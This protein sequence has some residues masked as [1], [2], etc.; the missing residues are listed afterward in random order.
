MYKPSKTT[1]TLEEQ[2]IFIKR[3]MKIFF[4]KFG[5]YPTVSLAKNKKENSDN[6]NLLSLNQL[7]E[8]FNM[9]LPKLYGKNVS[10][11]SKTRIRE[12][13]ELRHIFCYIAKCMHFKMVTIG[14]FLGKRDHSTV[15][16][17]I[18]TFENLHATDPIFREKYER[19]KKHIKET[20]ESSIMESVDQAWD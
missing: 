9:F 13:T 10:L 20:Y 4:T 8:C 16:H 1:Q 14:E 18:R 11:V 2:K 19:V 5:Y 3:F 6:V 17:S 7:S 15:I 12:V